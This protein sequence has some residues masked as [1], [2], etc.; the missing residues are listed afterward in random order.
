M[1]REAL[2]QAEVGG[3]AGEVRA[4]LES[5][6][7]ILRGE[8]RRRFPKEALKSVVVEGDAL[9]FVCAGEVVRLYLGAPVAAAWA[10]LIAKP[11]PTLRAKLG[12]EEGVRAMMFGPCDDAELEKAL[13]GALVT[14]P[15]KAAMLVAR[16]GCKADLDA[17]LTAHAACP[18]L[19]IW[20]VYPKGKEAALGDAAIR[21]ALREAGFRDTKSCAV[22]NRLT[23]TRYHPGRPLAKK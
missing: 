20:V 8:L 2:V 22:S 18:D 10:N 14:D 6:E 15:A 12:L 19:P 13:A 17:A 1:G 5:T 11:P 4:L 16:I 9:C 3:E 21:G 7:L 23:A